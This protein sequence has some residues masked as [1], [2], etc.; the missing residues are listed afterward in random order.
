MSSAI[1][2]Y[3]IIGDCRTA[4][5][6]DRGGSIDWFCAPRFD[7]ASIFGA[8]L[9]SEDQGC[10][11]LA[12]SDPAATATRRYDGDSM[13]L[14][15]RWETASGIAE[16]F[17][18]MPID[19]GRV[20]LVRRV[21]GVSG[22]VEFSTSL[23]MR[24]DYARAMPWVRQVGD[25]QAP[26]LHATAGPDTLVVRGVALVPSDHAHRAVFAVA[27]GETCD[28]VAT[29]SHSYRPDPGLLDVDAA[30]AETRDWWDDWA[31]RIDHRGPHRDLVVRS[32]VVLRALTHE[33]TGGIV[34]AATTSL[35]EQF[36][37][38]RNW[39]Y[40][41]VWLRDASLTLEALIAH[42]F[43]RVAERWRTWLLRAVAGDPAQMQI[44]YGL[45]G[46]RRLDEQE[47]TSLPGYQG[48][49][50]VR[51]GNGAVTQYQ[52]DVIG[53]VMVALEAA[54]IAGLDEEPFAWALQRALL[55]RVEAGIDRPDNGIWEVR[56]E[57]QMFTQSRAMM[58]AA[59]DRGIRAVE[60]F[61][62]DGPVERWRELRARIAAEVHA[63]GVDPAG[64]WFVQHYGTDEV[65]ASL[66]LLPQVGFCA[67]D[68]PR[69]VAT[70]ERIEQTLLRDGLV[71]RYRASTGVDGLAG[72]ENAFIACS[73]WLV[74]QYAAMGRTKDAQE[75]MARACRA[76]NDLGLVAEEFDAA[77]GRQA[78]NTPQAL[79][80]LALVGAADAL[81][82][83]AGRAAHRR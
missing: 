58:W 73:F 26:A 1:E 64:G 49:A 8:L 65:D 78:G 19:G 17:D 21:V 14:V 69:M 74:T 10:W 51:V 32:L 62:L 81:A 5:L 29:W 16:V 4:A 33:D 44:M 52:A 48:A 38:A 37:G 41:Y 60:R 79:S 66:L 43:L 68:D 2:D 82:G 75:L 40:R 6:V 56:G 12:P 15:T 27:A 7:S 67:P 36:G 11:R 13:I 72:G 39:D 54:R 63:R 34:A 42:G 83:H 61:G 80:H 22:H 23:R 76:A 46:E 24:F 47:L 28:L 30:L 3:A 70:V 31:A 50:P 57:P 59:F 53:E 77:S 71:Q 25:E 45:A 20:D 35:P 18:F 9:G 55:D